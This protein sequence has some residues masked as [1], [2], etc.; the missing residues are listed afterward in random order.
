MRGIFHCSF[1]VNTANPPLWSRVNEPMLEYFYIGPRVVPCQGILDINYIAQ[2]SCFMLWYYE[3]VWRI[4]GTG[5]KCCCIFHARRNQLQGYA[6]MCN[7]RNISC[8]E[9]EQN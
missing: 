1:I 2:H 4:K 5:T 7:G 3:A 6:Y 9:H 8:Y